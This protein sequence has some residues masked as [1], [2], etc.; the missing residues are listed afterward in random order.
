MNIHD[1]PTGEKTAPLHFAHFPTVWQAVVWRN[2]NLIA[3]E[4]LAELLHTSQET[5]RQAAAALGLPPEDRS[6]L[7]DWKHSGYIALIR[8]N[9]E[10][11]PYSQLLTLLDWTPE[12]MMFTLR[13]DDFLWSKVGFRK[14]DA[15][16]VRY[17]PLTPEESV[18]TERIR[19][20]M[21]NH[22]SDL[23]PAAEHPFDFRKK[24]GN[25]KRNFQEEKSPF[26]LR[27][28]YPYSAVYG[29]FLLHG[30]DDVLPDGLLSD[31]AASGVNARQFILGG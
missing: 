18:E 3:P 15:E 23:E 27:M 17:R 5:V 30:G 21:R 16:E 4:K 29:D 11:L 8:R 20:W 24:F 6:K 10:L 26:T 22:F 12:R 9:W 7:D 13:E 31:Y 28:V 19:M 2:W 1:L 14:P 25:R